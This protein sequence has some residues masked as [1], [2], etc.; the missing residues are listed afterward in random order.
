MAQNQG[1]KAG[2][3][4]YSGVLPVFFKHQDLLNAN[5]KGLDVCQAA[6]SVLGDLAGV[7]GAQL[8]KTYQGQGLW[9]IYLTSTEARNKLL[10]EGLSIGEVSVNLFS[11]NPYATGEHD[12]QKKSVK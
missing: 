9:R 11:Q 5:T 8:R 6:A 7:E 3:G 2:T 12:A 4:Q 1:N 10:A